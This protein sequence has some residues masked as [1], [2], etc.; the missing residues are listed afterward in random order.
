MRYVKLA[1]RGQG[2]LSAA[3]ARQYVAAAKARSGNAEGKVVMTAPDAA[4]TYFMVFHN[5]AHASHF[6]DIARPRG[7]RLESL[8]SLPDGVEIRETPRRPRPSAG[9]AG[10]EEIL[11]I[12]LE[13][14]ADVLDLL[15][16]PPGSGRRPGDGGK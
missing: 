8:M 9:P 4:G 7:V 14:A 12:F 13:G 16:R 10:T 1:V 15:L 6:I 2:N 11:V 5:H 3:T